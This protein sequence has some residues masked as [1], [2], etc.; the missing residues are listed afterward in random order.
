MFCAFTSRP[1][2]FQE[3]GMIAAVEVP[4]ACFEKV[5][6]KISLVLRFVLSGS[7]LKARCCGSDF[8]NFGSCLALP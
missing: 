7:V 5:L 1:Q 6:I 4:L 2:L 3:V 8:K